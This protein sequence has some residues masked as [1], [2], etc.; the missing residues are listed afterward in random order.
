MTI[1]GVSGFW[2]RTIPTSSRPER[3]G[4]FWSVST[5][6]NG[7]RLNCLRAS[8]PVEARATSKPCL[9]RK[10]PTSSSWAGS[11]STTRMRNGSAI[12]SAV[13]GEAWGIQGKGD[14]EPAAGSEPALNLDP[15][16]VGL[17]DPPGNGESK[18]HPLGLG[19]DVGL[20]DSGQEV[21]GDPLPGVFDGEDQ[22][23][24]QGRGP[25]RQGATAG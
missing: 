19:R 20:E 7:S 6:S 25:E 4:I 8:R 23:L 24:P 11:S 12:P 22:E 14:H 13:A 3:S 1:T 5:R 21:R 10:P 18:T 2:A 9:A 16:A 15:P 17:H